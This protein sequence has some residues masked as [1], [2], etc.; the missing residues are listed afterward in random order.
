M[1]EFQVYT[2]FPVAIDSYDHLYPLGTLKDNNSNSE[3]VKKL[4]ELEIKTLLDIGCAGGAFVEELLN[5]GIKAIGLEGSDISLKMKRASWTT[6]P[7]NLFTVDVTKPF[8]IKWD[9]SPVTFDVVTCWEFFEHIEEKD[10]PQVLE[11][12]CQ[13]TTIGSQ[14]LCSIASF[15]SPHKGVDLHRT[16]KDIGFWIALLADSGFYKD[17]AL[18]RYYEG[19]YVRYGSFNLIL[20]RIK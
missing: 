20:R 6:I 15:P 11:N 9:D 5:S 7:K 14:L 19:N 18:E 4:K 12:I 13:H 3:L 17:D 2:D 16:K 8:I 1:N 10:L